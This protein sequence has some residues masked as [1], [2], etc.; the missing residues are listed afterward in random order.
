[1]IQTEKPEDGK[2]LWKLGRVILVCLLAVIAC[3]SIWKLGE[4]CWE[5]Y[6]TRAY[7]AYLRQQAGI[8]EREQPGEGTSGEKTPG[9]GTSGEKTPGEGTSGE[10]TPGEGTSGEKTPGEGT[11]GEK[12]PGE[13]TPGEGSS[14]TALNGVN[15]EKL[16]EISKD[17]VAWIYI[18]DTEIDYVIV[19]ADDNDYYLRRQ[20]N[21]KY[22]TGGT[23]FMD[24]LNAP[25]FSDF[26]TIIYGH[27]M[28]NG[29]MFA[30]LKNY[31]NQKYYESHPFLYIYTPEKEFKV[32]LIAAYTTATDDI[33]YTRPDTGE[34]R[35]E[36]VVH[37]LEKSDF[38]ADVAVTGGDRLV[39]L[40]TCSYAFEDARYVVIGKIVE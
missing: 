17:V 38:T 31:K 12:T 18:P 21:G 37:A 3:V 23:L 26:N 39:T 15:F 27:N 20:L 25:D 22:A 24:Y 30:C 35:D 36:V 19:Q 1:M 29:T 8:G 4:Y 40:S 28:K 9:E 14:E 11:S 34:G 6:K 32:E 7:S 33:I 16:Q 13:G 5:A 2:K 10:G